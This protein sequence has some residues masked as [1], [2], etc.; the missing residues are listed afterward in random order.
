[1]TF[2]E[3]SQLSLMYLFIS[4][5][6]Y[7]YIQFFFLFCPL[8]GCQASREARAVIKH[9]RAKGKGVSRKERK[10]KCCSIPGAGHFTVQK[11]GWGLHLS[12]YWYLLHEKSRVNSV[13]M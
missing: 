6:Y 12:N 7:I 13:C 8:V 11:V 9:V 3:G 2:W 5:L 1:M 4:I 10:G